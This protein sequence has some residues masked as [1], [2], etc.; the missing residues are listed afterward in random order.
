MLMACSGAA[1]RPLD[2]ASMHWARSRQ[3][4]VAS[5]H[6]PHQG[7]RWLLGDFGAAQTGL[8]GLGQ[9]AA[10][11]LLLGRGVDGRTPS[12]GVQGE[13]LQ[14]S[15]PGNSASAA[16]M[17]ASRIGP[18]AAGCAW[19]RRRKPI[20]GGLSLASLPTTRRQPHPFAKA[21]RQVRAAAAMLRRDEKIFV[22]ASIFLRVWLTP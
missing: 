9:V 14:R 1:G 15:R 2:S 3:H 16:N 19:R 7:R 17:L 21:V 8:K 5:T 10:L 4:P 11:E 18:L 20:P 6:Q 13:D 12:T 22:A